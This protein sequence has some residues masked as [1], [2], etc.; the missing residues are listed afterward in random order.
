MA[1]AIQSEGSVPI[2]DLGDQLSACRILDPAAVR[3]LQRSIVRHGQLNALATFRGP[4]G[5]LQI[6][7]GFKR[8]RA[9]KELGLPGLVVRVLGIDAA[10][11]KAAICTLNAHHGLTELEEGWL[12]RALYRDDRLTQPA[13]GQLLH[14]HKSWVCRRLSL[15]ERLDEDLQADV[16]LGLI[17]PRAAIALARLP[18]GNQRAS[19]E[20]VTQRALTTRQAE[21]LVE[22]LITAEPAA[23]DSVLASTRRDG[24]IPPPRPGRTP[25]PRNAA[26]GAVLDIAQITRVAG[27]LQARLQERSLDA[28]GQPSADVLEQSLT[29]FRPILAALLGTL[30]RLIRKEPHVH[31]D[32]S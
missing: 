30:D 20:V 27:R 21:H 6:I 29:D 9:A 1:R 31:L 23:R 25:R 19:A 28:H 18:R 16:R 5:N 22:A 15:V 7:D 8:L 24:H 13:I 26:E 12:V 3:D 32:H 14:R 4:E 11:A 2:G 10:Q 17:A